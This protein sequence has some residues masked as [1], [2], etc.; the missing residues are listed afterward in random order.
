VGH[1]GWGEEVILAIE[2]IPGVEKA[3]SDPRSGSLLI[4]YQDT[5]ENRQAMLAELVQLLK[6]SRF[7]TPPAQTCLRQEYPSPSASRPWI[8]AQVSS[9]TSRLNRATFQ[10]SRGVIDLQTLMA[11]GAASMGISLLISPNQL[12]RLAG[13]TMLYRSY[14]LMKDYKDEK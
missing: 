11:L 13:A 1:P 7:S 2:K 4:R 3:T 10:L 9:L 12:S 14:C 5:P 8:N 6:A